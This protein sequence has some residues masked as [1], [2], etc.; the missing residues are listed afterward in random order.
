MK[1]KH[2]TFASPYAHHEFGQ[3]L[4][5][6]RGAKGL[7]LSRL[8]VALLYSDEAFL[9]VAE[10]F[11]DKFDEEWLSRLERGMI[12]KVNFAIV[13]FL[14]K[15]MRLSAD[16]EARLYLALVPNVGPL[17]HLRVVGLSQLKSYIKETAKK[18]EGSVR[19]QYLS[20]S[21]EKVL[22]LSL[23][24]LTSQEIASR[25]VVTKGTIDTHW[26][27]ILRKVGF[28]RRIQALNHFRAHPGE[29]QHI[30]RPSQSPSAPATPPL[31]RSVSSKR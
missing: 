31:L 27:R 16:E 7:T 10:A 30:T 2:S 23:E 3:A 24:G 28:R 1:A 21:E 22:R 4:R 18:A 20:P 11:A 29:L 14:V 15:A 26:I 12:K 8:A 6:L 25:L 13:P 17:A 9:N 5:E 19:K